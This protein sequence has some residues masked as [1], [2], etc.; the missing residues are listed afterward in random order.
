MRRLPY[1]LALLLLL[2]VAGQ[3]MAAFRFPIPEF[4]SGYQHP[5]PKTPPP[6]LIPPA[7]DIAA[8]AGALSV[9]AW[10]V[11]RRRSRREVLLMAVASLL[12]FGFYR[13]GCICPVG[14]VQNVANTVVGTGAGV[15]FV[16]AVFFFLPLLFAMYFGRVFCAGVCPLGAIQ[17]VCA[18]FPVQLSRPLEHVLGLFAYAY[19]GFAV[20]AI[21]T[22]AGF[23]VCQYD[24]FVG[25]FRLGATFNM[26]LA[27]GIL[28]LIGIFVARPYCRFLCPY[29]VLL[30]WA[31][32]FS[33]WHATITPAECIQCRL[34]ENSC[35]Y[36]AILIPT[37][38]DGGAAADRRAG[39]RRLGLLLLATP[40]IV[41][42]AGWTGMA[43]HKFIARIHPAVQLAERVAAE[44]QGVCSERSVESDAFRAGNKTPAD[45]YAQAEALR[46]RFK[47]ASALFGAFL[48]LAFCGR[49]IRL[50][51]IR[52]NR[53]YVPDRGACLSC[54][55]CFAYCPVGKEDAVTQQS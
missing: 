27:G 7:L 44:E 49:I 19:L 26:F 9:T 39:A 52:R 28:L 18:L 50:S 8:L 41:L 25:F 36:N 3:A 21:Y 5:M 20:L 37:P 23:F 6:R 35:P 34:C 10:L 33:K 29:G 43:A 16:V 38:E 51:V 11:L 12:W 55:R 13:K 2:A 47:T 4:E 22:G 45:L 30:R 15:P 32:I 42:F 40:I 14:S 46:M 17:E 54:A 24:P 48:G 31:S 1:I 53:D